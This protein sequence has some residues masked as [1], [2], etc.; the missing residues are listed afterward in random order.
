MRIAHVTPGAGGMYCG[1]CLHDN[2]LAAALSRGGHDVAL[3]PIYTPIRTDAESVSIDRVFYGAINVYLEQRSALFR[4]TP[5]FLDRLFN[6]RPLLAWAAGRGS[7]IDARGLGALTLSMLEGE[8]GRQRKELEQLVEWLSEFRPDLVHLSNALLVGMARRLR[9]ALGV[10]VL[11]SLQGEDLFLD[12]LPEPWLGRAW[13]LLGERA[14]DVDGFLASSRY[15]AAAM[16]ERL[17]VPPE[18]MHTVALGIRTSGFSDVLPAGDGSRPY[19]IGYLARVCP[20]KG[21][22]VLVEAFRLLAVEL[23]TER[24]RLEIAGWLGP[25]DREY[26]DGVMAEVR[27]AGLEERVR[28]RGEVDLSG[29]VAFLGQ[30]DVLSV[31]TTY[32]EP[33]GL[34]VL[35][36]LASGVPVVEPRHG[37]FP[38]ILAATGGGLLVEPDSPPAL[39]RALRELHDDP[40]RRR[41]LGRRGREVVLRDYNDEGMAERTAEVYRRH[42]P[43]R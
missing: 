7:T 23:G 34:Y 12:Q 10:P 27:T 5:R 11:C 32:R 25:R 19:T 9:G 14:R 1:S 36:A 21:L 16:L 41:E 8:E 39:A 28:Y 37:S 30:I 4:H 2:T 38:E 15:Y 31:P 42:A 22:H 35:E 3:I 6:A 29:K 24:V 13:R 26:L 18:R 17:Q 43:G 20:E 33:K 40:A